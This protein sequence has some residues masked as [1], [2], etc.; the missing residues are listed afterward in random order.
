MTKLIATSV[1][2]G[3]HQGESHG[4]VYLVDFEAETV[5]Q[6]IDWNTMEIDW[7]GRGWDRGL[8][9]IAFDG[10]RIFIAASDEIFIYNPSFKLIESHRNRYLKHAH[11]IFVYERH[12]FIT[13]TGF[14]TILTFDL[15]K[16][17]FS[18]AFYIKTD[19]REIGVQP[20]NPHKDQGPMM[21]NKFHINNVYCDDGGMY[22]SGLNTGGLLMFNGKNIGISATLPLGTHNARPFGEGIIFNDTQG[23]TVRYATPGRE[24]DRAFGTPLYEENELINRDL[25]DDKLA[26]QGFARGLC[27]ISDTMIAGGSS[28]S[29][30]A[31]YDLE[32]NKLKRTANLSMDIRNGIHG[33]EVWPYG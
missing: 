15:D 11:E 16:N 10:E 3:A 24:K 28:P 7:Q 8:R 26:R 20:F 30:I 17:N 1:V 22:I 13:S 9:G 32:A 14:D 33:L 12:L 23:N 18:R 4:G 6:P 21:L 31:L 5:H 19:G 27:V 25:G 29:T 2:R